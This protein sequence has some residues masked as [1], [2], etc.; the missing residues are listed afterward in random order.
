MNQASSSRVND[1]ARWTDTRSR[2][3]GVED[4]TLGTFN[5]GGRRTNSSLKGR[6]PQGEYQPN[7]SAIPKHHECFPYTVKGQH[8]LHSACS[9]VK[10]PAEDY[11]KAG[12]LSRNIA[13]DCTIKND[14]NMWYYG[15]NRNYYGGHV[16]SFNTKLY[17]SEDM[18][19]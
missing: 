14:L 11:R 10:G 19:Q 8:I 2:V 1:S 16:G 12:G 9:E 18:R 4:A 5:A 15:H 6:N 17:R 13:G 3:L 7:K